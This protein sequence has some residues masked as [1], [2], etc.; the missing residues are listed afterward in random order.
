MSVSKAPK[1]LEPPAR[2]TSSSTPAGRVAWVIGSG[3]RACRRPAG[4]IRSQYPGFHLFTSK[5]ML[6]LRRLLK[7]LV[8]HY[9]AVFLELKLSSQA[10]SAGLNSGLSWPLADGHWE[11]IARKRRKETWVFDANT[12]ATPPGIRVSLPKEQEFSSPCDRLRWAPHC[13]DQHNSSRAHHQ[14][15]SQ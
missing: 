15:A 4:F 12:Q 3:G 13:R 6:S 5:S 9:S 2:T 7:R 10:A 8:T 14:T 11:H 1:V